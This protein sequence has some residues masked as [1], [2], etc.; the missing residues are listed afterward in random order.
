MSYRGLE[1]SRVLITGG[2]GFI[3]SNLA[4][5]LVELGCS[6]T[7][8]DNL[9]PGMGGNPFNIEEI[10]DRVEVSISDI[11]DEGAVSQLVRGKDYIFNLAA[12]LSHTGSMRDPFTDL[13][14]NCRG[15]LTLL[16]A[17]RKYNRDVKIIYTGTRGQYGRILYSPVDE[18]HPTNPTDANGIT[19]QA[20]EQYHLLYHRAYGIR[21]VSLRLTNTYGPRHQMRHPDQGFVGWFVRLAMDDGTIKL[22]GDGSQVRDINYVDDVV[23]A[24]LLAAVSD[25][26]DG[27]VFNLG[28][29]PVRLID[30]VQE[31]LATTGRGK[32]ELVPYPAEWKRL[33]VGDYIADIGKIRATLG[34]EPRTSL[35]EGLRRM[36]AFY[37]KHKAHYW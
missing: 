20:A 6:V 2:L 13:D 35:K 28:A 19:K 22:F 4:H 7:I 18:K 16:E 9:A 3:G 1:G 26:A 5:R 29:S 36:V 27:E 11:R 34:W 25:R 37:E 23:E 21:A 17:C 33:E 10:K 14:I 8:M 32:Y 30:L 12:Q 24:M 15:H 31:L